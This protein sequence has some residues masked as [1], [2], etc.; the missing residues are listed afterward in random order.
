MTITRLVVMFDSFPLSRR[1]THHICHRTL[2]ATEGI[3]CVST[4]T[5]S[6]QRY[7]AIAKR[8]WN[9]S[10][11]I[12]YDW[13]REFGAL[14]S[15]ITFET[16][17]ELGKTPV[18]HDNILGPPVGIDLGT[19]FSA[20]ATLNSRGIPVAV[21]N[22]QGH[23][24]TPSV[25]LFELDSTTVGVEAIKLA[26]Y[27]PE[28]VV[29][30]AKR[31]AGSAT[32]GKAVCGVS[33]PPEVV[34]AV[35]LGDLKSDAEKVLGPI[36]EVVTT[37]PACFAE[38]QRKA[39]QDAGQLAGLRAVHLVNE[40]AAAAIAYGAA[41]GFFF[42]DSARHQLERVLVFD[43]GGGTFDA[44]LL[45]MGGRECITLAATGDARLGGVDWDR[46]LIDLVAEHFVDEHGIDPRDDPA[47]LARL[48]DKAEEAGR[49][50]TSQEDATVEFEHQGRFLRVPFTRTKFESAT[51]DLLERTRVA[52]RDLFRDASLAWS[53]VSRVLLAG[54][55]SRMPMIQA[56]LE[57]ESDG[58]PDLIVLDEM[59]V[60][61]GAAIFAGFLQSGR[62]AAS[63]FWPAGWVVNVSGH[64]LGILAT[65]PGTGRR[66][67]KIVLPRQTM[68]PAT[69]GSRFVTKRDDQRTVEVK[70]VEGGDDG[71]LSA[72]RVGKCVIS[73][74]PP[75]LPARTPVDIFF[76]YEENGRLTVHAKLQGIDHDV[77]LLIERNSGLSEQQLHEWEMRIR[78]NRLLSASDRERGEFAFMEHELTGDEEESEVFFGEDI[79]VEIRNPNDELPHGRAGGLE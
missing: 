9:D 7:P 74:L 32:C 30:H 71:G 70:I 24:K 1:V 68:L 76:R 13:D 63:R 50:L 16:L 77:A 40:P 19:A 79:S 2:Q 66:R 51:E 42:P 67:R 15:L 60:A 11:T 3:P 18:T 62:S 45:Q 28:R 39:I 10:R 69:A 29:F 36:E 49:S 5:P 23:T 21:P 56:M 55:A 35:V 12:E 61:F 34:Q 59:T 58:L 41:K 38:P 43:L 44:V 65:E 75:G 26:G 48:A 27:E 14:L 72:V 33:L 57:Q 22:A 52:V 53:D 78:E 47:A 20:A 8:V 46:R 54:G 31:H 25:V 6:C 73:D 4:G 64:D 17:P 37:V